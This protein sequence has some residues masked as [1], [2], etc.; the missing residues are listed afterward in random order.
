MRIVQGLII[1]PGYEKVGELY[2]IEAGDD[3][4]DLGEDMLELIY[5][6]YLISAGYYEAIGYRVVT[7][8]GLDILSDA[9]FYDNIDM[10]VDYINFLT[11]GAFL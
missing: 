3:I 8:T 2:Q 9:R 7:S 1:P 4:S 10:T 6:D 11:G 5:G